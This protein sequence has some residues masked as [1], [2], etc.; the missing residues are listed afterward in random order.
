LRFFY[1]VTLGWA[2]AIERIVGAREPQR[3]PVVLSADEM[4]Q[5]LEAAPGL[6]N[7]AALTSAYGAGL[8]AGEVARLRRP[9]STAAGC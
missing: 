1:G 7:R 6:R 3:L 2:D 9:P 8:R 5:F 4:V